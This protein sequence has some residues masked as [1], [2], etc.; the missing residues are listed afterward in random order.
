[1]RPSESAE[2]ETEITG[3]THS[4][5]GVGRRGEKA[6]FISGALPGDRVIAAVV[7][8]KKRFAIGRLLRIVSPSPERRESEC[9]HSD[10]CGGCTYREWDYRGQTAWKQ[11]QVADAFLRIGGVPFSPQPV[12]AA[13]NPLR[14]RNRSQFP[15][16]VVNGELRIGFF[17]RGTH[18]IVPIGECLLQHPLVMKV[19]RAMVEELPRWMGLPEVG[20]REAAALR[21]GVIRVSTAEHR[22][23]L[24]LVSRR[25][26]LPAGELLAR[27]LVARVP[28]LTGVVH[29]IRR[30]EGSAVWGDRTVPI[31]GD[32]ELIDAIGSLRFILS[33]GSF[34]QVNR[35]QTEVL[36]REAV[37][38]AALTGTE[39][40][41]DLYS[42]VG[43]IALTLAAGAREVIGVESF[44]PAVEDARRNGRLNGIDNCR[45]ETGRAEEVL[46]RLIGD[47]LEIDLLVL[48]PPREGCL[49]ELT[50]AIIAAEVR[51]VVYIS[52]NPS[53]L[54][55]DVALLTRGGYRVESLLPIDL[56]P[57][58]AHIETVAT[59]TR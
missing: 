18:R 30:G 37:R 46:P 28:E 12:A 38:A 17:E 1:M 9:P 29:N 52:C 50:E 51:R 44:P 32:P 42:G 22:A 25:S 49:P 2:F 40:V 35:E 3:L 33:P 58:T 57:Y 19:F 24:A 36:Y 39:R 34:F 45:F 20:E 53:T 11:R 23:V 31:W 43:T 8:E 54:A 55:R 48:D 14:Y 41:V 5:E 59:L 47:G 16:A 21:H 27:R 10:R 13:D 15:I 26:V 7:E 4:G 56:F 6:V